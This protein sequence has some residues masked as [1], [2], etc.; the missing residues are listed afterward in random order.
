MN[1]VY[2]QCNIGS[3]QSNWYQSAK[4]KQVCVFGNRFFFS[5][6]VENNLKT[7]LSSTVVKGAKCMFRMTED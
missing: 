6:T 3:I 7:S 5:N 1:C 2:F 4:K